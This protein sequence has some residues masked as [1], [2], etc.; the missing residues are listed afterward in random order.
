MR[1]PAGH[2]RPDASGD[3]SV[4][5]NFIVRSGRL[6]RTVVLMQMR[7]PTV[8]LNPFRGLAIGPPVRDPCR[9]PIPGIP[10]F[11]FPVRGSLELVTQKTIPPPTVN[12]SM[13]VSSVLDA[14]P[15]L[16]TI[17]LQPA[18]RNPYL[19]QFIGTCILPVTVPSHPK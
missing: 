13:L 1:V 17:H 10:L 8:R 5:R 4:Y 15:R 19:P 7:F 11:P 2:G 6:T 3:C 12:P 14:W 16:S 18:S 9:N